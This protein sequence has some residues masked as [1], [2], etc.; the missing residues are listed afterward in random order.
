MHKGQRWSVADL[1]ILRRVHDQGGDAYRVQSSL[2]VQRSIC[3][4]IEAARRQRLFFS[5]LPGKK[6][7]R[8]T[9]VLA[10]K[11]KRFPCDDKCLACPRMFRRTGIGNRLC[12]ECRHRESNPFDT[13]HRILR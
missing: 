10:A 4:I 8:K 2:T 1:H 6:K 7:N 11:Q 9:S 12:Q 13:P 3:S 5:H